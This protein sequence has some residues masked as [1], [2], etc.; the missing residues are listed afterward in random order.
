MY[1]WGESRALKSEPAVHVTQS[2]SIDIIKYIAS[3]HGERTPNTPEAECSESEGVTQTLPSFSYAYW[4]R[5]Q[6]FLLP[7]DIMI[8]FLV[9]LITRVRGKTA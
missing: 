8:I 6:W 7:F 5:N 1:V 3:D 2:P 4:L 9:A